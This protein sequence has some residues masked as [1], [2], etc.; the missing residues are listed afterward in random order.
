MTDYYN[1]ETSKRNKISALKTF[2]AVGNTETKNFILSLLQEEK[3]LEVKFEMVHCIHKI[4]R[5]F[6]KNYTV[7]DESENDIVSRIVLH[8]NNPYLN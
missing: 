5:N 4:D 3:D 7:E 1:T 6:F 2:G 8:V